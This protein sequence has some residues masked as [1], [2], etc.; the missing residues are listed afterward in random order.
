MLD[1]CSSFFCSW[2]FVLMTIEFRCG[3]CN[4]LLRVPDTAAGKHARCPTCQAVMAV[5]GRMTFAAM[6]GEE[7]PASGAQAAAFQAPLSSPI[8]PPPA[9]ESNPFAP[10]QS[11]GEF[12][13]TLPKPYSESST[14]AG[15]APPSIDNLNPYASP[16][17][18][19][20][21]YSPP[22]FY[23]GPRPGLPWENEPRSIGCWFRTMGIV[24]SSPTRAFSMM[25]QYGGLGTPLLY[26][27][28]AVSML[29]ALVLVVAIPVGIVIALANNA[30]NQP[31]FLV[32]AG[33][34]GV[35]GLVVVVF[36]AVMISVVIPFIWSAV[37]HLMLIL[38]GGA[39]QGFETTFRVIC[40]GYFSVLL[41]GMFLACVPYLGGLIMGIWAIVIVIFGLS[42]AHE[43]SGGKATAA[44]LTPIG[45]CCG[46]YAAF[47][48]VFLAGPSIM[49]ALKGG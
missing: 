13:P 45:L 20:G 16:A 30:N 42:R 25:R 38:F 37:A 4:Q 27:L 2:C 34:I 39:R 31:D 23:G 14:D 44:V 29:F 33:A 35:V 18:A 12:P 28:Y 24:L 47:I 1:F 8:S 41:P 46:L 6:P 49:E 40:F 36:Y 11:A 48:A 22:M 17:A 32:G 19:A 7:T 10:L 3:Q 26:N 15:L 5:P 9:A 43:I 21:S